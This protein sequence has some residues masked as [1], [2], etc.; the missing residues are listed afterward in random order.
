MLPH[1]SLVVLSFNRQKYL[2]A[3]LESLWATPAGSSY[4][5]IICDDGSDEATQAYIFELVK[6]KKVS[7]ALFNVHHNMGI[8][9]AVNRGFQIARGSFLFKLDADLEY[10]SGWL[11]EALWLLEANYRIG[12][13]GL[14]KYWHEPCHFDKRL[15]QTLSASVG[16]ETHGYHEVED[17]V[18][19]AV[20]MRREVYEKFGPW[21][22]V[23]PGEVGHFSEDIVFKKAVQAG[24]FCMALPLDDLVTNVG[25]GEQH[26]S[27]I[28]VID[29]SGKGQHQYNWP[30]PRPLVFEG[31]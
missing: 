25:F 30:D 20:C 14:F 29:W 23:A 9:I 13:L 4:E 15:I 5:L 3:S 8:G 21:R 26:S 18:G 17:F 6:A 16:G 24:G 10:K 28:K 22:E 2:Q 7:A 12:C 11:R 27:L 31:G 1:A 19:S